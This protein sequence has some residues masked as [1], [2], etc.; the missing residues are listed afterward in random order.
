MTTA[1]LPAALSYEVFV[2][3]GLQRAGDQRMPD[4]APLF[5]SPLSST[6]VSGAVDAILVD[7][8]LTSAQTDRVGD[9]IE[10]SGRRLT[11]IYATHGHGDHWYG[12]AQLVERFPGVV[13]Y[14]TEGSIRLMRQQA[15][16]GRAQ[17]WEK[18]FPGQ[19]G[20]T[21]VLARPIPAEGFRLEGNVVRAYEVGH[22]DTDDTTVLHVPS[23]GLVVAG[24]TLYND[25][26][27]YLL[28][29]GDGG[30]DAWLDAIDTIEALAPRNVVAGHKNRER[31]DTP[32]IIEETRQYLR[33]ARGLLARKPSPREYF[34]RMMELHGDR[35]N[36]GPLWYGALGLLGS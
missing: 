36:P 32:A 6:L 26:H 33:D 7:P 5:S 16:E 18:I 24:D 31:A 27:P 28:E 17:L 11:H 8:P 25:V 1:P 19:I 30:L 20:D 10:Q 2:S 34:D 3:D 29:S 14:A 12:A 15:V 22:T 4:G 21:T 9:W 13:V 23:I 35:L